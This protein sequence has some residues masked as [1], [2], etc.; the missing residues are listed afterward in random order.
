LAGG[1]PRD[2]LLVLGLTVGNRS[3]GLVAVTP[4]PGIVGSVSSAGTVPDVSFELL[5]LLEPLE[6]LELLELLDAGVGATTTSVPLAESGEEPV[7]ATLTV[8][9]MSV[10][11]VAA[12]VV[13]T[14]TSNS[15]TSPT[16]RLAMVHVTPLADGQ[17]EKL[18]LP[19]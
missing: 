3:D 18:G 2:P 12:E 7:A 16:D 19:R 13:G 11:G 10:S 9:T 17:I 6:L 15:S 8:R 14:E 4:V 5:E 1:S